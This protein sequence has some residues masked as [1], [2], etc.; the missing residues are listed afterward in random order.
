[1]ICKLHKHKNRWT[2]HLIQ[3]FSSLLFQVNYWVTK[4][5]E[6]TATILDMDNCTATNATS[7]P[8][9]ARQ[10]FFHWAVWP[11]PLLLLLSRVL[12]CPSWPS[13]KSEWSNA[14]T[15]TC[16]HGQTEFL[17]K[18]TVCGYQLLAHTLCLFPLLKASLHS[19]SISLLS[20]LR[21]WGCDEGL[22]FGNLGILSS[23]H[24]LKCCSL[25]VLCRTA[26]F[27]HCF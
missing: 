4:N 18:K 17:F 16:H 26:M 25:K 23:R 9:P 22:H 20:F 5:I 12:C 24:R 3:L 27:K 1:M 6:I 15:G 14:T 19:C 13:T 21:S 10:M 11:G 8:H 2:S 7:N